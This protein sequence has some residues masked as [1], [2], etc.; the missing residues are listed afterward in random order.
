MG[1]KAKIAEFMRTKMSAMDQITAPGTNVHDQLNAKFNKQQRKLDVQKRL[2]VKLM[3]QLDTAEASKLAGVTW[4][5]QGKALM[6]AIIKKLDKSFDEGKI[7][8]DKLDKFKQAKQRYADAETEMNRLEKAAKAIKGQVKQETLS[9][10]DALAKAPIF[11]ATVLAQAESYNADKQLYEVAVLMVWSHKLEASARALMTGETVKLKAKAGVTINKWIAKQDLATLV[12]SRQL[13]DENGE[14]WFIGAYSMPYNNSASARRKAKGIADLMARKAAVMAVYADLE[15][16]KQAKI[17]TQT[18][19]AEL[20]DNDSIAVSDSFAETTRQA[21]DNRHVS[22]LSKV[23]GKEVN[24]PISGQP[25]Y[26]VVYAIS[27]NSAKQALALEAKNY[28]SQLEIIG[29][30]QQQKGI[31]AGYEQAV[32]TA[33]ASTANFAM[34]KEQA[35]AN[36]A[37]KPT[38]AVKPITSINRK[39]AAATIGTTQ[40]SSVLNAVDIDEDDF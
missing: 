22:G 15:T 31:Q 1:G 16:Y 39:K 28:K 30:Q 19:N 24:H 25:I 38:K 3:A 8:A 14:R 33:T 37:V 4:N 34:G 23:M 20:G 6:N 13:I 11:G 18:R 29:A 12:G 7:A 10:I 27:G 26:V 9:E 21:I 35:Q 17:A 5:D 36:V 2:V 32:I 40:S